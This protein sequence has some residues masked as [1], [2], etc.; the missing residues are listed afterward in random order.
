MPNRSK[1]L[2][3]GWLIVLTL[4]I[5]CSWS[6]CFKKVILL[7]NNLRKEINGIKEEIQKLKTEEESKGEIFEKLE[8]IP[9]DDLRSVSEIDTSNW[10]I[11]VDREFG[12]ELKFPP[13][14]LRIE[15]KIG[16]DGREYV[17]FYS[18]FED[19]LRIR[20]SPYP[21]PEGIA[22]RV[23]IPGIWAT[24]GPKRVFEATNLI[25]LKK[26]LMKVEKS[27]RIKVEKII[28][29]NIEGLKIDRS[30]NKYFA[31]D[32]YILKPPFIMVISVISDSSQMPPLFK[33]V[34][35][36]VKFINKL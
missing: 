34:I 5:I 28:G 15:R 21:F 27:S 17:A 33:Q 20:Y 36:S 12:Y 1:L 9:V 24:G 25:E 16:Y 35:R 8:E 11:Y 22:I 2:L 26:E 19:R 6:L 31:W 7:E 30:T 14:E 10:K 4:G 32:I 29:D 23:E 3:I 13:D 18:P